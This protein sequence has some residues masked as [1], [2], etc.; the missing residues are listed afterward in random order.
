MTETTDD[1]LIW[2]A[3]EI[4]LRDNQYNDDEKRR[5]K[6]SFAQAKQNKKTLIIFFIQT[7]VTF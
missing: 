4:K 1:W 3:Q 7:L 6:M 2:Q 5:F